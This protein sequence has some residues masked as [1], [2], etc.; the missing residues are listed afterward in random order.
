MIDEDTSK[1]VCQDLNSTNG[2]Y[3]NNE[4]IMNDTLTLINNNDI[5]RFGTK[6]T[7]QDKNYNYE[8]IIKF[9]PNHLITDIF[10]K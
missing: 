5:I 8:Y 4:R 9:I 6:R 2:V 10:V 1:L 3:I 7:F